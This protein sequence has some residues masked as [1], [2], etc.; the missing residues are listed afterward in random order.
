MVMNEFPSIA[1]QW[2]ADFKDTKYKNFSNATIIEF[3]KRPFY[4]NFKNICYVSLSQ[5]V[6]LLLNIEYLSR[7]TKFLVYFNNVI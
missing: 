4:P 7:T 2:L 1:V 5:T 6:F 3:K